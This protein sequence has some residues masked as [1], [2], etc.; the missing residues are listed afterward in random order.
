M[1]LQ[2]KNIFFITFFTYLEMINL[3]NLELKIFT[4]YFNGIYE[5]CIPQSEQKLYTLSIKHNDTLDKIQ[6]KEH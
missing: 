1:G 4:E 6:E 2:K 3:A 5:N